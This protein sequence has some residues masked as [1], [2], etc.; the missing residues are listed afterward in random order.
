MKVKFILL[1]VMAFFSMNSVQAKKVH[2]F[3]LSGQSNMAGMKPELGLLPEAKK[4]FDGEVVYLKVAK[5]GQ[6]ISMW[7]KEWSDI[8]KKNKVDTSRV[9]AKNLKVLYYQQILTK[10]KELLKKYPEPASVTFC[11]MQGER[12]AKSK[13]DVAYKGALKQLIANL[14]RDLKRPDMNVVIGRISDYGDKGSWQT[15]RQMQVEVAKDDPKGAWIDCDDLND[16]VEKKGKKLENDLHYTQEG[17][18]ILGERFARQAK[19]LVDDNK[20]AADGRPE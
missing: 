11:W 15:V 20:P 16:G 7:V 13:L 10:Y 6:P 8:A 12:D 18:K 14:R 1:M 17:Y 5:G 19:A 2:L 9:Q 4:L 3:I